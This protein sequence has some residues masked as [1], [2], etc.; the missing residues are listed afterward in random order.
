MGLAQSEENVL[1]N[2]RISTMAHELGKNR[3]SEK[4]E[5]AVE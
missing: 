2:Y 5:E 1:K 4:L 3:A